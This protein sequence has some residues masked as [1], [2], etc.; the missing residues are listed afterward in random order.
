[1]LLVHN[2]GTPWLQKED[3]GKEKVPSLSVCLSIY[4]SNLQLTEGPF[5]E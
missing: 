1:M 3:M 2:L 5:R 4:L